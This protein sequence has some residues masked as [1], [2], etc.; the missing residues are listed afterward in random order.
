[1]L[2]LHIFRKT[3]DFLHCP[4][5]SFI[6]TAHELCLVIAISLP[7]CFCRYSYSGKES[8][9]FSFYCTAEKSSDRIAC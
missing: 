9:S 7:I 3:K 1:M 4:T 5:M 2:F 8:S 6:I